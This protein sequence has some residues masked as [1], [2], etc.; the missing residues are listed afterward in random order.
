MTS[1][2]GALEDRS[3]DDSELDE[4]PENLPKRAWLTLVL[5]AAFVVGT[6]GCMINL[7]LR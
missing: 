6:S 7:F 2:N 4:S 3:I 1:N 5:F